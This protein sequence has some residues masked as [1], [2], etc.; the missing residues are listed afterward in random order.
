MQRFSSREHR[1]LWDTVQA[2]QAPLDLPEILAQAKDPIWKLIPADHGALCVAR[3]GSGD[4]EYDWFGVDLRPDL[5]TGYGHVA[6][7]DFVRQAALRRPGVALLDEDML[8][9]AE[10]E[11]SLLYRSCKTRGLS[12]EQILTVLVPVEGAGHGGL[13]LYR[14]R[15]RPFSER[16]RSRLQQLAPMLAATLRTHR[17][18]GEAAFRQAALEALL[19]RDG[20]SAVLVTPSGQELFRSEGVDVLLRRWFT[21][22]E[23]QRGGLP[24]PVREVIARAAANPAE[25][26]AGG[27]WM[28]RGDEAD[29]KVGAVPAAAMR[30]PLLLVLL[31]EVPHAD[32]LPRAWRERLTAGQQKVVERVL[33][34]WDNALIADDIGC[35]PATVKRHLTR[36][37][38][39]LGVQSRTALMRRARGDG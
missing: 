37:F 10:R 22:G 24:D 11:R 2:L 38:D 1:L 33:R 31:E 4:R 12:L 20:S 29:L 19:T 28:R 23:R 39:A 16:E 25:A 7:Q 15:R 9:R 27:P 5:F 26:A 6:E 13:T 8:P 14:S 35:A 17:L 30:Q 32:A 18:L 34:G 3:T 36:V 21:A